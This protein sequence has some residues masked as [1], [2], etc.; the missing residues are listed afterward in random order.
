M[1]LSVDLDMM[2]RLKLAFDQLILCI[3]VFLPFFFFS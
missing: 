2:P 1:G 3:H